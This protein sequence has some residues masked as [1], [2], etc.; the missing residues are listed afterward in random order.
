MNWVSSLL[1]MCCLMLEQCSWD[2]GSVITIDLSINGCWHT[3]NRFGMRKQDWLVQM[4]RLQWLTG[5]MWF[6]QNLLFSSSI[7][8]TK[9]DLLTGWVS[10]FPC[11]LNPSWCTRYPSVF[12]KLFWP[13]FP[14]NRYHLLPMAMDHFFPWVLWIVIIDQVCFEQSFF[15]TLLSK[16][17]AA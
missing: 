14:Y 6:R 11:V 10:M 13:C 7:K 4:F 12:L 1:S 5:L 3:E 16:H 8:K 9:G 17:S 15:I 2:R